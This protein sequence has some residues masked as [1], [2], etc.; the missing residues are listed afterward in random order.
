M[1]RASEPPVVLVKGYDLS[2]WLLARIESFPKSQRF[3]FGQ[4]LADRTLGVM[5]TLVEAAYTPAG[6]HKVA[7]L[8]RANREL[9]VL[10]W[11]VRLAHERELLTARQLR[12]AA[13]TLEECGRMLGGW[14]K[15]AAGRSPSDASSEEARPHAPA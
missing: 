8:A 14:L 9:E 6:R 13:L 10:R 5:E 11:L 3:V 15:Q 2:K 7:L 12:Y 4:R 1:G